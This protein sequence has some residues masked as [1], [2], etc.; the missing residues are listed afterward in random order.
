[1]L[2]P[3]LSCLARRHVNS[4]LRQPLPRLMPN[5]ARGWR[6]E[7]GLSACFVVIK[8]YRTV[9][10]SVK[11]NK[12][13]QACLL[14]QPAVVVEV[15][16]RSSSPFSFPS[17]FS[18]SLSPHPPPTHPS[19]TLAIPVCKWGYTCVYPKT[20]GR[21]L[22]KTNPRERKSGRGLRGLERSGKE[23]ICKGKPRDPVSVSE[24]RRSV[25]FLFR[26]RNGP[27]DQRRAWHF[28]TGR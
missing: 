24:G 22:A 11:T 10:C 14:V 23:R 6:G 16:P 1:M 9:C 17:S 12:G 25:S 18:L 28:N 5:N 2:S 3:P 19:L 15:Y 13:W 4:F 8:K 20:R 26:P 27:T 21:V 7:E